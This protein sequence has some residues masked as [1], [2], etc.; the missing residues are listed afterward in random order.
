MLN[1]CMTFDYELFFGKNNGT[2]KEI[3]FQPTE[4]L[5]ELLKEEKVS[6]TFFVD[7]CSLIQHQKIGKTDYVVDMSNQLKAL[8]QNGQD[9]QLHIHSHW[10]TSEY[11]NGEWDFD[12]KSYRL[13][14]YGFDRNV[15]N[16]A[17]EI[18]EEGI[19]C[20]K[21]ILHEVDPQYECIAYRAGGFA[22][23]PHGELVKA[24]YDAGIRIDSSIAPQ[25]MASSNTN[26]Y[27]YKHK[28]KYSN[29]WLSPETEWWCDKG[30]P[31]GALYEVPIATEN[32]NPVTFILKRVFT[33]ERIKLQLNAK[34]GTYIN[35]GGNTQ[36]RIAAYWNYIKGYS[37]LS[38]DAYNAD[39]LY[40]QL[41]RYY[42]KNRCNEKDATIA[43]I[44]HPKLITSEYIANL[45]NF[46]RLI[47]EDE[48][49]RICSIKDVY[50]KKILEKV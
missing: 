36:N 11:H 7:V 38:L 1:I 21:K 18:I 50:D 24:L 28:L 25:L 33:P 26:Y 16:N 6:A 19:S 29:W 47:R 13:H 48:R 23:Q 44:G 37:A 43:V 49:F 27:Q 14:S 17:F 4:K 40:K 10:L 9:L 2:E 31:E 35:E 42:K 20:L 39:F 5:L 46:I 45:Q 32:K 12:E 41:V 30:E 22:I 34:K 15:A 8:N 3:L